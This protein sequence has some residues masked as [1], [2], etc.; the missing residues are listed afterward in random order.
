[1][2]P[3]A[4]NT[5]ALLLHVAC[6]CAAQPLGVA[7][8]HWHR[9]LALLAGQFRLWNKGGLDLAIGR[10]LLLSEVLAL[11]LAL[12]A[13]CMCRVER[14]PARHPGLLGLAPQPSGCAPLSAIR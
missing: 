10:L 2:R 9:P 13:C 5:Q 1:M 11:V 4:S 7:D 12:P 8:P 6:V 14:D 3:G